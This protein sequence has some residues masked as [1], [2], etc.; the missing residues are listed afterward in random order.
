MECA[1]VP[2]IVLL[3]KINNN[4][5]SVIFTYVLLRCPFFKSRYQYRYRLNVDQNR[6]YKNL[7]RRVQKSSFGFYFDA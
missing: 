5:T 2:M 6:F 7:A 4:N 3:R 1:N